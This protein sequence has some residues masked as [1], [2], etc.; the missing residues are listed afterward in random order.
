VH[1]ADGR[2]WYIPSSAVE[3]T[4]AICLGV[5]KYAE[6]EVERGLP[7]VRRPTACSEEEARN[8]SSG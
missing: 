6:F 5:P 4:T 1:L 8:D 3:V 2:R 7:L